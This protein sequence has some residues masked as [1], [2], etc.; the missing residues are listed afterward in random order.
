MS[1]TNHGTHFHP[2]LRV[3]D[4]YPSTSAGHFQRGCTQQRRNL[5]RIYILRGSFSG[6]TSI[7]NFKELTTLTEHLSSPPV[8]GGVRVAR[9]LVFSVVFLYIAVCPFVL[10]FVHLVVCP[11]NYGF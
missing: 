5:S 10:F 6:L 8:L 11:F 3:I 9:S 4:Y 1:L 7:G 2:Y